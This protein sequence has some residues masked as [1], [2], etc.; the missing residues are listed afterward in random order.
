MPW[1][2]AA[3]NDVADDAVSPITVAAIAGQWFVSIHPFDDGNGRTRELIEN[4]ILELF[5][6]PAMQ[7]DIAPRGDNA[8]FGSSSYDENDIKQIIETSIKEVREG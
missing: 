3:L 2:N 4:Y 7:R 6:Y 5:N 8:F 1:L